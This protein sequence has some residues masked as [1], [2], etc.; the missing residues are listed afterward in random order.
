MNKKIIFI[1][2]LISL[3]FA[4]SLISAR[5][6]YKLEV[7]YKNESFLLK[8]LTLAEGYYPQE[9]GEV[10]YLIKVYDFGDSEIYSSGF[11]IQNFVYGDNFHEN[12]TIGS[13]SKV[14]YDQNLTLL[15]PYFEDGKE[16]R[17]YRPLEV[18]KRLV[19]EVNVSRYAK[20]T[21]DNSCYNETTECKG[22][23]LIDKSDSESILLLF[24][25]I[26]VILLIL[27][28]IFYANKKKKE[29]R[30]FKNN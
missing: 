28:I 26:I 1:C 29:A 3:L 24:L 4:S 27:W 12:G 13:G 11:F 23:S 5:E 18:G 2:I 30:R 10:N 19:L 8:N 17:I 7:S 21:I 6:I 14:I 15:I 22:C 25:A 9:P 16:V 20:C